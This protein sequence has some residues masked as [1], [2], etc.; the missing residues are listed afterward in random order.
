M[1]GLKVISSP[2]SRIRLL[3]YKDK[4]IAEGGTNN[5]LG[6][7]AIQD[8]LFLDGKEIAKTSSKLGLNIKNE[9][10]FWG[11][12]EIKIE[13][14]VPPIQQETKYWI[15]PAQEGSVYKPW[16]YA[17]LI[18]EYDKLMA[19]SNGYIKKI[20]YEKNSEPILTVNGG[21]ELFHYILEPE[22]YSKTIFIQAGIHGNEMDSKQQLLRV[23]DILVNKTNQKEY[24]RFKKIRDDVRL[25]IIPCVS[26]YGHERA[27][28]NV[29]YIYENINQSN[30]INLNRN[31]DFNQQFAIP[32]AGVGGYP[33]F[34]M[35]ETQHTRDILHEIGLENISYAMDWHDGGDVKQHYWISYSVD[36][37]ISRNEIDCFIKYLINKHNIENPIIPNC[38]DTS[39]TGVASMYFAKTL[40]IPGSTVE[41]IGGLLGYEFDTN[42]MTQSMEIRGN[43]LLMAYEN[44]IKGW[45]INEPKDAQ[46]FHFDYPKAF[47]RDGLRIDASDK[48]TVVT[49]EKIYARWDKLLSD[50]PNYITKSEKLGKNAHGTQDIFTYTFGNGTKKVLYVGGIMRYGASHKIDEFAIYQLIEYLCNDYIV[51]QSKLLKN[52]RDNYTIIVLPCIDNQAGNADIIK[53]C[54]LNNSCL[55]FKKWEIIDGKCQ[56]TA[57]ALGN[58]DIPILKK[59]IDDNQD[60]KCIVSGGEIMT[61]YAGNPVDYSTDFETHIV[62][63]MNVIDNSSIIPYRTHLEAVRNEFVVIE[64]TKGITFGDYAYDNYEIPTYFIQLKASKRFVELAEYHSLK[65]ENYLYSNYEA[66]RRM[67]NIVNLFIS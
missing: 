51:N 47:T 62:M 33:A 56:P 42:H 3:Y 20:R 52:L 41:W 45:R 44:D 9:K 13:E 28:M 46:Y 12:V 39:T 15:P 21:F 65:E 5:K 24:E 23:V 32:A 1:I 27:S 30:G 14:N 22:S 38:K 60:L 19:Q 53:H 10:V 59:I 55:S 18:D 37:D 64:N 6:L 34:D 66:G 49:D 57:Y 43:M 35:V 58:H 63:P 2:T 25:I 50:Y 16:S 26:P 61:G 40:G 48:R 8:S 11:D 67:A 7:Y 29:P 17:E 36:N 31:Y 4:K 54:G